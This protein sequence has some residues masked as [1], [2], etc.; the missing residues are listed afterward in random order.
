MGQVVT[1]AFRIFY[2]ITMGGLIVAWFL[3]FDL[4]ANTLRLPRVLAPSGYDEQVAALGVPVDQPS[5]PAAFDPSELQRQIAALEARISTRQATSTFDPAELQA[6]IANLSTSVA[7]ISGRVFAEPPPAFDPSGI[8]ARI[9]ELE[10]SIAAVGELAT[11]AF[12]P[13][14]LEARISALGDLSL[15]HI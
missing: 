13:S 5:G 10:N 9:A 14:G 2:L 1:V 8:K 3:D 15:I 7:E 12:D 4:T 11:P 6:R